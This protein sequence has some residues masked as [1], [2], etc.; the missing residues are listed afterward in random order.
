[1][2]LN[3]LVIISRVCLYSESTALPTEPVLAVQYKMCT[4]H[5]QVL[6]RRVKRICEDVKGAVTAEVDA[7]LAQGALPPPS[8]SGS[9]ANL[10]QLFPSADMLLDELEVRLQLLLDKREGLGPKETVPLRAHSP[11]LKSNL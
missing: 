5:L 11:L 6:Q 3:N 2:R 7:L 8:G 10:M 4:L 9:W 1:M